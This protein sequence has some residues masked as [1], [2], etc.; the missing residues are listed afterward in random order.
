MPRFALVLPAITLLALTTVSC[1]DDATD[2]P[3][4]PDPNSASIEVQVSQRGLVDSVHVRV[5]GG[6]RVTVRRNRN[7]AFAN[8]SAGTHVV[9]TTRWF[10]AEEVVS[11]RSATLEIQLERGETRR[12]LFH[13]DFPLIAGAAPRAPGSPRRPPAFRAG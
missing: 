10:F 5:D 4:C 11:S 8:L 3:S 9:A 2:C 13:N 1:F 7:Y 6:P 12:I